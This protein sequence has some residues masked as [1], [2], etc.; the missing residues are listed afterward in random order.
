MCI[1]LQL[2]YSDCTSN[3]VLKKGIDNRDSSGNTALC[4]AVDIVFRDTAKLLLS[5]GAD[6]MLFEL[7]SKI[8]LSASLLKLEK[9]LDYCLLSNDKPVTSKDLLLRLKNKVSY[10]YCSSHR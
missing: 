8:L 1:E 7:D 9:I 5:E 4:T 6:V 2:C 3:C 10:E